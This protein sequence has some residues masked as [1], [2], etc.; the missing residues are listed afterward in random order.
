MHIPYRFK[1]LPGP[2]INTGYFTG[3]ILENIYLQD[4]AIE[5]NNEN[6]A[7][8]YNTSCRHWYGPFGC[9]VVVL[10][11]VTCNFIIILQRLSSNDC[12]YYNLI[13]CYCLMSDPIFIS[14][15]WQ[16][17]TFIFNLAIQPYTTITFI[18]AKA[19]GVT[20]SGV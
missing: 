8:L 15:L 10:L 17:V 7:S 19:S 14:K 18:Q 1:H 5:L 16:N 2:T 4:S 12:S 6:T 20:I 13:L 9:L 3:Y 11:S